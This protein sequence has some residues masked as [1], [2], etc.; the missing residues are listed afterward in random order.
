MTEE[1]LLKRLRVALVGDATE[2][3]VVEAA[4]AVVAGGIE[5][6]PAIEVASEAIREI[7]DAFEAGD[8]YLPDL[9]IAGRK[10]ERTMAILRPHMKVGDKLAGGGR[11]ILGTVSGDI[12]D[13]GKNLVGTMLTVGGFTV[14]DLGV[15]VPPLEFI[16][17]AKEHRADV[18]ALSA[19]MTASLP[20]QREVLNLLTELGLREKF[21]VI[22]G[23]GPVTLE[24]A[25]SV[26]ADGWAENAASALKLCDKLT[27][28]GV[29]PH[30][31]KPFTV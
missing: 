19:L 6:L 20:Y 13:I 23:G 17:A 14:T 31:A 8:L 11:V 10:M 21:F 29:K 2:D 15:N 1:L 30:V 5:A 4:E 12:H 24:F 27:T 16:K 9:M 22:V 28:A 18:I 3:E 25:E 26:G 7:G